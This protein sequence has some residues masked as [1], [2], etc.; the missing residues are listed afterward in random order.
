MIATEGRTYSFEEEQKIQA[1]AHEVDLGR[2]DTWLWPVLG[3][4]LLLGHGFLL[5]ASEFC[6]WGI[7]PSMKY[8]HWGMWHCEG[9]SQA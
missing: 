1:I 4:L 6:K 2:Q 3:V 5:K 9:S 8:S 7:L